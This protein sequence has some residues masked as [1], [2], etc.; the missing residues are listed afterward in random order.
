MGLL[1]YPRGGS[2]QVVRYLARR[3]QRVGWDT[4]LACGSLGEP[5]ERTHAETFFAGLD[6]ARAPTTARR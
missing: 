4:S 6:L 5:G 2:A 3:S 1:F